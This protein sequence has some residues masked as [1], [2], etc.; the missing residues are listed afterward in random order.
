MGSSSCDIVVI[1]WECQSGG[2]VNI[3]AIVSSTV[4]FG[5]NVFGMVRS[6]THVINQFLNSTSTES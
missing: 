2:V 5:G 6:R 3:C 1:S 4:V